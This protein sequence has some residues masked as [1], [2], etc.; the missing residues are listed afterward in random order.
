MNSISNDSKLAINIFL[1]KIVNA[2]YENS[3]NSLRKSL[4]K[5][6]PGRKKDPKEIEIHDWYQ[7]LTDKDRD[8]VMAIVEKTVKLSVFSFLVVLDNKVPG[9]PIADQTSDYALYLQTYESADEMHNY[10]PKTLTRL[11][12]SYT[13]DGELHD[14]F[15]G[16]LVRRESE[17]SED[18]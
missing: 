11:N 16:M 6:P 13:I 10:S 7:K 3:I 12:M 9:P 15:L 17:K 1:K 18:T 8:R 5:G 4:E 14:E 2:V